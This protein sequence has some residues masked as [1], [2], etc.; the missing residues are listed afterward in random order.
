MNDSV[1]P[2]LVH[3]I[4]NAVKIT[5]TAGERERVKARKHLAVL[6]DELEDAVA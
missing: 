3:A 4:R 6:L 1:V 5:Q 2:Y